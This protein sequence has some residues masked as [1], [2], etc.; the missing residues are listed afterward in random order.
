M[1]ERGNWSDARRE[2]PVWEMP[3]TAAG[4]ERG[5]DETAPLRVHQPFLSSADKQ[6]RRDTVSSARLGR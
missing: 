1:G 2:K 6:A 3:G 4:G 5:G